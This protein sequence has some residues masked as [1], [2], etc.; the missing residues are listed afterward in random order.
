MIE[1][2]GIKIH[3]DNM[4]LTDR[5]AHAGFKFKIEADIRIVAKLG[6]SGFGTQRFNSLRGLSVSAKGDVF[7]ADYNNNITQVL[8]DLHMYLDAHACD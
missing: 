3:R 2:W 6:N 1:T 4:Y 8:N 7:I 5:E